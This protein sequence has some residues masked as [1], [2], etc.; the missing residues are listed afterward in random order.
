MRGSAFGNSERE[1]AASARELL[2]LLADAEVELEPGI[3][4]QTATG[5]LLVG[6]ARNGDQLE[7]L[8]DAVFRPALETALRRYRELLGRV[9]SGERISFGPLLP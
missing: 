7:R 4:V 1:L 8:A 5:R 2:R 6:V 3:T 9:A